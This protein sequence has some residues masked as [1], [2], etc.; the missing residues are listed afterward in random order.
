MQIIDGKLV[1]SQVLEE[2]KG[3]I[4]RLNAAGITPAWP[5]SWWGMTPLPRYMSIPR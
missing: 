4:D 5:W 3:D 1:A 2:V